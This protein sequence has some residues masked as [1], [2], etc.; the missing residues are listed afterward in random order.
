M[1]FPLVKLTMSRVLLNFFFFFIEFEGP[2]C[3]L[4]KPI[5][6]VVSARNLDE[7][8]VLVVVSD[9]F[10]VERTMKLRDPYSDIVLKLNLKDDD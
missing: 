9:N 6:M 5:A 1:Q 4:H 2:V 3:L 8:S 7:S 10:S